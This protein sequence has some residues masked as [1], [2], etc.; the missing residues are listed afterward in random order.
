MATHARRGDGLAELLRRQLILIV[1]VRLVAGYV[2]GEV[3]EPPVG[4]VGR[5]G[6]VVLQIRE[7]ARVAPLLRGRVVLV[8][9]VT[10]G[11]GLGGPV[12]RGGLA[13]G[14]VAVGAR[15]VVA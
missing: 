11:P 9:A 13:L 12:T 5:V 7:A 2:L 14:A 8:I 1:V 6:Q 3:E 10:A 15:H 4:T